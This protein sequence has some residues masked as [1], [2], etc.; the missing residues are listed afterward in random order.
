MGNTP[1][2][3]GGLGE[4]RSRADY[5]T[6]KADMKALREDFAALM[7][8]TGQ[9]AGREARRQAQRAGELAE[10]AGKELAGYRDVVAEKVREHPMATIGIA[11]AVG[12]LISSLRRG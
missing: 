9:I 10:S 3:G 1:M 12:F 2:T 5:D 4:A 6:L 11:L 7:N 8:D